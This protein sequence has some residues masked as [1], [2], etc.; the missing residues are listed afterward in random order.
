MEV[1]VDEIKNFPEV[2]P[3]MQAPPPWPEALAEMVVGKEGKMLPV[4]DSKAG[5]LLCGF[6]VGTETPR[7]LYSP[8]LF[9]SYWPTRREAEIAWTIRRLIIE[10]MDRPKNMMVYP[11]DPMS[12]LDFWDGD[13]L[14]D[15]EFI[16]ALEEHFEIKI[17]DSDAEK[18]FTI[19]NLADAVQYLIGRIDAQATSFGGKK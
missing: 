10:Q 2:N 13:S 18:L 3:A 6:P 4:D 16:V 19:F 14:E 9:Y 7:P 17:P 15:V 11:N 8:E 5:R 1:N 12:L